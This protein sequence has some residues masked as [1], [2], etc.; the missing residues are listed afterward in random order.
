MIK[1]QHCTALITISLGLKSGNKGKKIQSLEVFAHN[2]HKISFDVK[3]SLISIKTFFVSDQKIR[4]SDLM[5]PASQGFFLQSRGLSS[6][7]T[8]DVLVVFPLEEG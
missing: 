8:L 4:L 2:I 3:K 7:C 6:T 1:L 5:S